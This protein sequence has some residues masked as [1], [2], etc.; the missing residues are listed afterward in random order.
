MFEFEQKM[1]HFEE[2]YVKEAVEDLIDSLF[3]DMV[4][5]AIRDLLNSPEFLVKV[6]DYIIFDIINDEIDLNKQIEL[7]SINVSS[8]VSKPKLQSDPVLIENYINSLLN[9]ALATPDVIENNLLTSTSFNPLERLSKMQENE[10]GTAI[11]P[12]PPADPVIPDEFYLTFEKDENNDLIIKADNIH[13]KMIFDTL[14]QELQRYRKDGEKGLPMPWSIRTPST[15]S[16]AD[17]SEVLML[18]K[19]NISL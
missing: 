13:N 1:N 6:T 16:T 2:N 4:Y 7:P 14:N 9:L 10:I 17:V 15:I 19:N 5:D 12:D 11:L 8:V 3:G 18:V